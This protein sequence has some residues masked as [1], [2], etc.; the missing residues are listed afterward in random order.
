MNQL[1]KQ[2]QQ[3]PKVPIPASTMNQETYWLENKGTL[4]ESD[5]AIVLNC[6]DPY[7][8]NPVGGVAYVIYG[9]AHSMS[10][11]NKISQ[12]FDRHRTVITVNEQVASKVVKM[13]GRVVWDYCLTPVKV[14]DMVQEGYDPKGGF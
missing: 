8:G 3:S 2:L 7:N 4:Q 13:Y 6:F 5:Y 11:V 12:Q 9:G 1:L 14:L 10:M